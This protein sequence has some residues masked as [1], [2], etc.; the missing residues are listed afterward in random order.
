MVRRGKI[1]PFFEVGAVFAPSHA[2]DAP[3]E[4][5]VIAPWRKPP[6]GTACAFGGPQTP[7]HKKARG[8]D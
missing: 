1:G 7:P 5:P 4:M 8:G 2:R 6:S 3:L